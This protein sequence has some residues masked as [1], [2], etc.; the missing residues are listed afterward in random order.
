[1]LFNVAVPDDERPEI[2]ELAVGIA[3]V[4]ARLETAV[5]AVAGTAVVAAGAD[6]AAG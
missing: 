6:V 4:N 2:A 5:A 1:M 3:V